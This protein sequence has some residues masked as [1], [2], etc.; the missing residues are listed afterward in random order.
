MKGTLRRKCWVLDSR[1]ALQELELDPAL[2]NDASGNVKGS[3]V[4]SLAMETRTSLP[5]QNG[6]LSLCKQKKMYP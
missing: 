1:K 4:H 6:G 3:L 2:V 5:K